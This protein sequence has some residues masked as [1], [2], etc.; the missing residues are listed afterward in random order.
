MEIHPIICKKI[1]FIVLPQEANFHADIETL[2]VLEELHRHRRR[3]QRSPNL[4]DACFL[5][6]RQNGNLLDQP[7]RCGDVEDRHA[8]VQLGRRHIHRDVGESL[9][10]RG[11]QRTQH[12]ALDRLVHQLVPLIVHDLMR[13]GAGRG[14]AAL[15]IMMRDR[16]PFPGG[17]RVFL[18]LERPVKTSGDRRHV[19]RA[20]CG[21][22][23]AVTVM[24][25]KK[26][27]K[28]FH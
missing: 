20:D 15:S 12:R 19:V 9:E 22:C 4:D 18:I 23:D 1:M 10:G 25:E 3:R 27:K 8:T 2:R 28:E 21:A 5:R 17:A 24:G 26:K 7:G 13:R 14:A 6:S 11:V 16:S